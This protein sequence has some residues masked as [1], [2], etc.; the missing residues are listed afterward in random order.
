M[1]GPL[2]FEHVVDNETSVDQFANT[3]AKCA[4]ML[5]VGCC[6]GVWVAFNIGR[7]VEIAGE[8]GKAAFARVVGEDPSHGVCDGKD[9][10]PSR[11]QDP[12]DFPH[13]PG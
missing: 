13:Q 6:A 12:R 2:G 5:H 1:V 8:Y 11:S 9:K 4:V 7:A 3:V 10:A